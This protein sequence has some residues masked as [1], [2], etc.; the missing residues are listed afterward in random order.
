[1]AIKRRTRNRSH[2]SHEATIWILEHTEDSCLQIGSSRGISHHLRSLF[3]F[4]EALEPGS[5]LNVGW[6]LFARELLRISLLQLLSWHSLLASLLAFVSLQG[7]S[8]SL[9]GSIHTSPGM[10][11]TRILNSVFSQDR[12]YSLTLPT[13]IDNEDSCTSKG[14][15]IKPPFVLSEVAT[16]HR[17]QNESNT[18]R[19]IKVSH[20]QGAL[21][22]RHQVR[23]ESSADG[24]RVLEQSY[25]RKQCTTF[26]K[27]HVHIHF[28]TFSC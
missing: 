14:G 7:I 10:M 21:W 8:A 22:L 23:Q 1:M 19:S 17:A 26:L 5:A 16:H 2:M 15:G 27:S 18:G 24:Q 11:N 6:R 9:H 3:L 13:C 20:H 4:R 28:Y 12:F 25:N